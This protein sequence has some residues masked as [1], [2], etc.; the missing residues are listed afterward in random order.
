MDAEATIL[1]AKFAAPHTHRLFYFAIPPSV[2]TAAAATVRAS[3]CT[4]A[5][6]TRVVVEK[7]FGRDSESSQ[8]LSDELA[9]YFEEEQIYR[10][11]HYLGKE[12]VQNLMVLRFA[13]T[14]FEPLWNRQSISNIQVGGRGEGFARV[15]CLVEGR[16]GVRLV[17]CLITPFHQSIATHRLPSRSRLVRRGGAATLTTWASSET[18]C[19]TTCCR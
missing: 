7:P 10:I 6:W 14:V 5:G 2:F 13:N 1:E 16:E 12:M 15:F 9:K 18:S 8:A 4:N 11:D 19:R 3:G 17:P